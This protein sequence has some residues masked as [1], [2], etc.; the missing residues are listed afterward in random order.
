MVNICIEYRSCTQFSCTGYKLDSALFSLLFFFFVQIA[1]G[2]APIVWPQSKWL[3]GL[4][5]WFST[6]AAVICLIWFG[7]SQGWVS[8]AIG[9]MGQRFF[10]VA[11][12]LLGSGAGVVGLSLIAA[13]DSKKEGATTIRIGAFTFGRRIYC[14]SRAIKSSNGRET[15]FFENS[16]Y[17]IVG[18]QS[19]DGKTLRRAQ[20]RIHWVEAPVL[21]ATIRDTTASEADVRHGELA[22][23]MVGRIVSSKATG[24][25][26]GAA[27]VEEDKLKSYE[28]NIP[29]KALSFE[30]WSH[31]TK[32]QYGLGKMPN[33]NH[34]RQLPIV[35]SADDQKSVSIALRVDL[36]D[37]NAPVTLQVE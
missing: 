23:F 29:A 24:V 25:Y 6:I 35:I 9:A 17:L 33:Q 30:V 37:Q 3:A 4:I 32:R 34:G 16:F 22:F 26:K 11:L 10:G 12:L 27:V 7:Y 8:M 28:V 2:V 20:A 18:N 5:L 31:E 13:G 14:E 1:A 36:N 15:D 21:L 19:E